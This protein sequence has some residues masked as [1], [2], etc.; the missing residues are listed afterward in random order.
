MVID[1]T[2]A[3]DL[4]RESCRKSDGAAT[5]F[6]RH[7]VSAKLRMPVFALCELSL[8]VVRSRS[9]SRARSALQRLSEFTEVIYPAPGFAEIYADIVG[10][11]LAAGTPIPVMDA[12]ISTTAVQHNEPL[13]TRDASH[14][15]RVERLTVLSY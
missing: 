15:A 11:L 1:T 5:Q 7:H 3:V 6:L 13:V 10:G 2:F 8:G 14:Y 12:L 9:Q 4:I